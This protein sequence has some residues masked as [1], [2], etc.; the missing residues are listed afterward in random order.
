[1]TTISRP[2]SPE[3]CKSSASGSSGLASLLLDDRYEGEQTGEKIPM[4][5]RVAA[6]DD[7]PQLRA[8]SAAGKKKRQLNEIHRAQEKPD[9]IFKNPGRTGDHVKWSDVWRGERFENPHGTGAAFLRS[10]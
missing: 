8:S 7:L 5:A 3:F 6:D 2:L 10:A 1:M 9:L 4:I